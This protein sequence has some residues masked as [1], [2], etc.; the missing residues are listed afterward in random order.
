MA[1][2][3]DVLWDLRE[4]YRA[5][6]NPERRQALQDQYDRALSAVLEMTGKAL[7]KNSAKYNAAVDALEKSIADL[8]QAKK[9][10]QAVAAAITKVA[11]TVDAIVKLAEKIA[12]A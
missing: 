3:N 12:G 7:A 2:I 9:A 10:L 4:T 11:K 1:R 5:E 6:N 8:K